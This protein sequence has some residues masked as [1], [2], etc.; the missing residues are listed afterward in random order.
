VESAA[1]SVRLGLG[2]PEQARTL[3]AWL[4]PW[5][6]SLDGTRTLDEACAQ[7]PDD[8][9]RE[10][11]A[12]VGAACLRRGV[13]RD[14]SHDGPPPEE[15]GALA[16]WRRLEDGGAPAAAAAR[17]AKAA[18]WVDGDGAEAVLSEL[19]ACGVAHAA[20][21]RPPGLDGA[22]AQDAGSLWV[23]ATDSAGLAALAADLPPGQGPHVLLLRREGDAAVAAG[24]HGARLCAACL[25]EQ[26]TRFTP[27]SEPTAEPAWLA[28]LLAAR[29]AALAVA[30]LLGKSSPGWTDL[31]ADLASR[32]GPLRTR[33]A[34]P[35]AAAVPP[36]TAQSLD[37]LCRR[38]EGAADGQPGVQLSGGWSGEAFAV[39]ATS[40]GAAATATA[41]DEAQAERAAVAKAM[42]QLERGA[43]DADPGPLE[44]RVLL[45]GDVAPT[46]G[47]ARWS[48]HTPAGV[49][50]VWVGARDREPTG[51]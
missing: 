27:P 35:C 3:A 11:A 10:V 39:T 48:F 49:V 41:P 7:L 47:L 29:G 19:R 37:A 51:A 44:G 43:A 21:G 20:S 42:A 13:L 26:A 40:L 16:V 18:V 36:P 22:A 14:G 1:G 28:P 31:R 8:G 32:R 9:S 2:D 4:A 5:L 33:P 30:A 23:H 24:S 6:A 38:W 12:Q 46:D 15:T 25:Q 34:C 17:L 50:A 45:S